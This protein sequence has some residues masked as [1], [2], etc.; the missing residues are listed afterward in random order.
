M[1]NILDKAKE[2][3]APDYV[4]LCAQLA[5]ALEVSGWPKPGNVHRTRDFQETRFEH[6]LAGAVAMGPTMREAAMRGFKVGKGELDASAL[7]LG[8]LIRRAVHDIK[9]WH[10]G[11]NTHLGTCMLFI[12]LAAAAGRSM[13]DNGR[14]EL[15]NLR[16]NVALF[17]EST[18]PQDATDVYEAILMVSSESELGRYGAEGAPDL[19]DP[20]SRRK[21]LEGDISLFDAMKTASGWDSI[22]KE[23]VTVMRI[24][25]ELGYPT[26]TKVFQETGDINVATV[27]TFL[28]IL[29]K[30]PDTFIARKIG[31]E[32]SSNVRR[33]VGL[34]RREIRWLSEKAASI[35]EKGGLTT[36]EGREAA[37]AL[38]RRLQEGGGD[39]NPGTTADLT[40]ASLM[41]GL[42]QGLRF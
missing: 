13:V 25:F 26:L 41:I 11:G 8:K 22:A 40:S 7:G 36:E 10:K 42:L 18:T 17:M 30:V 6:F 33:A 16:R 14:I 38:D 3:D 27:H 21:L 24:S 32:K 28:T 1:E 20:E 2:R 37:W 39:L 5:A 35:L 15:T 31:H 34:G 9:L 19:Y 29:S 12:P 4:M 23:L